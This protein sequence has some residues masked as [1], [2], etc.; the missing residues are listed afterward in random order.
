MC[1]CAGVNLCAV[2]DMMVWIKKLAI[3]MRLKTKTMNKTLKINSF[4]PSI[5][6]SNRQTPITTVTKIATTMTTKMTL[7]LLIS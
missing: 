7:M 4:C 1:V 5:Q 6:I 2:D 3:A